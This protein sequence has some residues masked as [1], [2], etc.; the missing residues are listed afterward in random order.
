MGAETAKAFAIRKHGEQRYDEHPYEH[1]LLQVV[2]I[3]QAWTDD[4]DLLAAA[5]LHDTIEDTHTSRD[6]LMR[7]FGE[8][9]ASLVW[10][11]TAEGENRAEKMSAIY[12][13]IADTPDAALVKLADRVANVEAA[14]PGSRHLERYLGEHEGFAKASRPYVPADAWTRMEAA[15]Q[16]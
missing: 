1:H 12:R 9:V 8:R 14:S 16:P 4:P 10:A 2:E 3:L 15:Y 7:L 13:K 6:D 5:W 11:V